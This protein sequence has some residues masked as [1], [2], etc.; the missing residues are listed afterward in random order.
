MGLRIDW[1]TN[2]IDRNVR[3]NV[4]CRRIP[5]AGGMARGARSTVKRGCLVGMS[6]MVIA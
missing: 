1:R 5:V 2:A 4:T 3:I 6:M